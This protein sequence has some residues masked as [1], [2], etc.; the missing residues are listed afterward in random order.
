[1]ERGIAKALLSDASRQMLDRNSVPTY[2]VLSSNAASLT[3]AKSVGYCEVF[4]DVACLC[5][6]Y[7]TR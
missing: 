1:M 6:P 5:R 3:T 2:E 7:G 4:R